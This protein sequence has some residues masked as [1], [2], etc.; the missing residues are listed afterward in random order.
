MDFKEWLWSH[1]R[2]KQIIDMA[3]MLK[4]SE[5]EKVQSKTF[6]IKIK[7]GRAFDIDSKKAI[8]SLSSL[9]G[10]MEREFAGNYMELKV[11][12]YGGNTNAFLSSLDGERHIKV[13]REVAE[14]LAKELRL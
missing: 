4:A 6:F 5:G 10:Q 8:E 12:S 14:S 7:D 2:P 13:P 3:N 9:E 11:Q 1:I